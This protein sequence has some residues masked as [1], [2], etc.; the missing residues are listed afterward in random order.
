V[1]RTTQRRSAEPNEDTHVF[2]GSIDQ[3][4]TMNRFLLGALALICFSTVEAAPN[5]ALVIGERFELRSKAL[6]ETRRYFVHLPPRYRLSNARYPVLVV[7]D[8]DENFGHTSST[9]DFLS[10]NDRIPQMIVV[11]VPNTYRERDMRIWSPAEVDRGKAKQ[12]LSFVSDELLAAVDGRYRTH[13]YR[14]LA[15]H[16]LGGAYAVYALQ[17]RPDVFDAYLA[18]SPSFWQNKESLLADFGPF[19][20]AHPS[21]QADLFMASERGGDPGTVSMIEKVSSILAAKAPAGFR[22]KFVS[23]QDEDHVS[24]PYKSTHEGLQQVFDGW[25]VLDPLAH[26][27]K[28]GLAG[29]EAHYEK[30]SQR[31]RYEVQVPPT[32]AAELFNS[33]MQRGRVKESEELL[34]KAF[35]WYPTAPILHLAGMMLY[36]SMRDDQRAL[37]HARKLLAVN[38]GQSDARD[39]LRQSV[40]GQLPPEHTVPPNIL[41]SFVG[42]Y[43]SADALL[44]VSLTNGELVATT[45][46]GSF[47]LQPL[48]NTSFYAIDGA[49]RLGFVEGER[50]R[51]DQV[52]IN[53]LSAPTL[54]AD[55]LARIK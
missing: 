42:N 31:M 23:Y 17:N 6:G 24:V 47:K 36:S 18:I 55:T 45:D 39:M 28:A 1:A 53:D 21:L 52:T 32:V 50:G 9:V 35:S 33:L 40:G 10:R 51:V 27:D 19:L 54:A 34:H 48:T 7:L 37:E 16:S 4:S 41:K 49:M 29:L 12:F 8:G 26:Y 22:W 38:P 20:E 25:F 46:A 15:G 43:S 14:V 2:V 5:E 30:V 13:S 3:G 44:E 11:G